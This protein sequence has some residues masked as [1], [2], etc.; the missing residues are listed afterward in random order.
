MEELLN[1]QRDESENQGD[2]DNEQS[3]S[4]SFDINDNWLLPIVL[5][6]MLDKNLDKNPIVDNIL[7]NV[8]KLT[9]NLVEL[10]GNIDI[11]SEDI[12]TMISTLSSVKPYMNPDKSIV[13]D[14]LFSP[15]SVMLKIITVKELSSDMTRNSS[16]GS[17]EPL[18]FKN[19]RQKALHVIGALEQFMDEPTKKHMES[20]KNTLNI[21]DKFQETSN[22]LSEKRKNGGSL[23]IKDIVKLIGPILGGGSFPNAEKIDG[24]LKMV[25]IMSALDDNPSGD[26]DI[27]TSNSEVDDGDGGALFEL[28]I[29]RYDDEDD[30]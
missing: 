16:D 3:V 30:R 6:L 10:L 15:L 11:S 20:F 2:S 28:V 14:K 8:K 27:G 23:D 17:R 26:I 22:S 9:N 13:I 1:F 18:K 29:D 12:Q 21:I 24:M 19:Q 25:Q 7:G 4:K 5:I